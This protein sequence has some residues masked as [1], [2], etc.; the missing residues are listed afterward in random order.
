MSENRLTLILI[1][2]LTAIAFLLLCFIYFAAIISYVVIGLAALLLLGAIGFCIRKWQHSGLPVHESKRE[3]RRLA[4]DEKNAE[5]QRQLERE[6]HNQ[7]LEHAQERHAHDLQLAALEFQLKQHVMLTRIPVEQYGTYLINQEEA[8][9]THLQPVYKPALLKPAD[10]S[11]LDQPALQVPARYDLREVWR[12]FTPSSKQ[13]FLGR[14]A[15]GDIIVPGNKLLHCIATG[16]TGGGKTNT[17]RMILMQLVYIGCQVTLCDIH[18]APIKEDENGNPIDWRPIV[19]NLARPPIYDLAMIIKWMNWLAFT[20][21]QGRIDRQRDNQPIG[22]PIFFTIAE[23]P[24]V[25]DEAGKDI[26][27][28]LAKILR[29]GRQYGIYF[30]GDS[31][32]LLTTTLHMTTGPRECFR[33]GYYTGGDPTTAKALLDLPNGVKVDEEGLGQDGLMYLKTAIHPYQLARVGWASNEA[34]YDL[35]ETPQAERIG[36]ASGRY[37]PG[38]QT[39]TRRAETPDEERVSSYFP[40]RPDAQIVESE[41]PEMAPLQEQPS[42]VR[43]FPQSRV[44]EPVAATQSTSEE[45]LRYTLTDKEIDEFKAAYKAS[46]NIDKALAAI[47]KGSNYREC[48]RR[49]IQVYALREEA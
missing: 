32:D 11:M 21:L 31:Q 30:V 23:L 29:Q 16:P 8:H 3:Y 48:A 17:V 34:L 1:A 10:A 26:A 24:A 13:I 27:Q 12:A 33:T 35:F 19:N 20:E 22:T 45:R 47:G 28:P 18:Y 40:G 9:L 44:S 15:Q 25:L 39:F 46:G 5:H 38:A 2:S 37:T 14:S 7:E 6:K 43:T 49:I 4:I 42:N 41:M 36:Y